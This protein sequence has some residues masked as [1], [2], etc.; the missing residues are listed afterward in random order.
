M[1]NLED[2]IFIFCCLNFRVYTILAN[3]QIHSLS[4]YRVAVSRTA[5]GQGGLNLEI[6]G[7]GYKEAQLVTLDDFSTSVVTF[8]VILVASKN[9]SCFVDVGIL[10][11]QNI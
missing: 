6:E 10:T 9:N 3:K 5:N 8:K 11:N 1:G 2:S 7:K 4:E